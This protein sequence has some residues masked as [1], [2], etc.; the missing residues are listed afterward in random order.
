MILISLGSER[1]RRAISVEVGRNEFRIAS[2]RSES[3]RPSSLMHQL[4]SALLAGLAIIAA[5]FR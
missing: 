1:R 4:L 5:V 2:D 3:M